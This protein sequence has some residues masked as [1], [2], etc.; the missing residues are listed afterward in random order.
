MF[1]WG[2]FLFDEGGAS[3]DRAVAEVLQHAAAAQFL[4]ISSAGAAGVDR[5]GVEMVIFLRLMEVQ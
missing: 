3:R 4:R 1:E 5:G 2:D